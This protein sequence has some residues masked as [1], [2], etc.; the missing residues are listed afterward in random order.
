MTN[1]AVLSNKYD[2]TIQKHFQYS[3]VL[4]AYE[5]KVKINSSIKTREFF[6][7]NLHNIIEWERIHYVVPHSQ[8][9]SRII[10]K[11]EHHI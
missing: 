6:F 3:N 10:E 8:V 2:Q 1:T 5:L 9:P 11:W 4:M 7:A